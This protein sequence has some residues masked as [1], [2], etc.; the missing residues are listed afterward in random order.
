[1]LHGGNQD[2]QETDEKGESTKNSN[3]VLLNRKLFVTIWVLELQYNISTTKSPDS[4]KKRNV[5]KPLAVILRERERNLNGH[6]KE[7]QNV[8]DGKT[9]ANF[10][11]RHLN[12]ELKN[13]VEHFS[14]NT[15]KR[16][17]LSGNEKHHKKKHLSHL[18]HSGK[19]IKAKV[20]IPSQPIQ[21][22]KGFSP[23]SFLDETMRFGNMMMFKIGMGKN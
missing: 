5:S 4:Y 2:L 16:N 10:D 14:E 8:V 20:V 15:E 13:N 21:I 18:T 1:M 23:F 22:Y 11:S 19:V 9:T 7:V 12:H 3:K 6:Q 17:D